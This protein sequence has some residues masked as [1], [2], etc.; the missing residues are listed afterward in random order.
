V[1]TGVDPGISWEAGDLAFPKAVAAFGHR[2][3]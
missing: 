2:D 1:R 3:T